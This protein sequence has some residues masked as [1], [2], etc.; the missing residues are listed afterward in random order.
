MKR[1]MLAVVVL[2]VA[3]SGCITEQVNPLAHELKYQ[4]TPAPAMEKALDKS[5]AVV[6]FEDGRMHDGANKAE[7]TSMLVNCIPLVFYTTARHTHP[8]VTYNTSVA[9]VWKDVKTAGTLDEAMPKL[10]ADYLHRSRRFSTAV[11]VE[12]AE[13]KQPHDYDFVLRGK[14]LDANLIERRYSYCLGPAALAAHLLGAPMVKYDA[15]LAVEWE[16]V[17]GQG[18]V[19]ATKVAS[20]EQPVCHYSGLYYGL[21]HEQKDVP[22]GLYVE[23]V[24][25]VNKRIAADVCDQ[26]VE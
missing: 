19:L 24:R 16:L 22:F 2:G 26:L 1:A 4:L 11:F 15:S 8:E 10:L 21:E 18:K 9:G 23:A 17:D 25:T 12:A 6:P 14:L 3:A 13:V 7:S 20:L 5:I